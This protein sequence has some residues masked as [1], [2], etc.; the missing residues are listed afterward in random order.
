MM[1]RS[2]KI[3]AGVHLHACI[4]SNQATGGRGV[5]VLQSARRSI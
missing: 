5:K 1:V 4:Y 2:I 3:P